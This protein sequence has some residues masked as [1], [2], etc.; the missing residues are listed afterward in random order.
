MDPLPFI[1]KQ[2]LKF[3]IDIF[4]KCPENEKK[5]YILIKENDLFDFK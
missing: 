3:A 5:V 2:C 1:R 4:E